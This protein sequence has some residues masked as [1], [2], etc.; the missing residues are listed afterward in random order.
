MID[1]LLQIIATQVPFT[2]DE[3]RQAHRALGSLDA[4]VLAVER[5]QATGCGL[6]RAVAEL[7]VQRFPEEKRAE[8]LTLLLDGAPDGTLSVSYGES[9]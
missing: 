8:A 2:L 9:T 5:A 7:A 1:T 6:V 4:V 3:L